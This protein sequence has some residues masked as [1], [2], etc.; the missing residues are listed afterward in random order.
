MAV[1]VK[2]GLNVAKGEFTAN[3]HT[4]A[5]QLAPD[6][7]G[8]S[9]GGFVVAYN[10]GSLSNG[11]MLLDFYDA[12]LDHVALGI[13]FDS[14]ATTDAIGEPSLTELA[15]GNVLVVWDENNDAG[16]Q[17][18]MKAALFEQDGTLIDANINLDS[19][20]IAHKDLDV[21]ALSNGNFAVS[22]AFGSFEMFRLY[23]S[24]GAAIGGAH[25]M[26]TVTTG[27]Q[28]DAQLTALAGGGFAAVWTD[29]NTNKLKGRIFEDNGDART[30]EF[31]LNGAGG[32]SQAAVVALPNGNWAVAFRDTAFSEPGPELAGIS[33]Q[34]FTPEGVDLISN[35]QVTEGT[36]PDETDPDVTVL[37]NGF[38]LVSWSRPTS[39]TNSDIMGRLFDQDGVAVDMLGDGGD[40]VITQSAT[41]D[42]LSSV[43][44]FDIGRFV[45]AWQDSDTVDGSSGRITG[46][47]SEMFRHSLGD[48]LRNLIVGDELRDVMVGGKGADT[49]DGGANDD[50]LNGGEGSDVVRG[51]EGVDLLEGFDRDDTIDGGDG[52][53][54]VYT[55]HRFQ[56][57]ASVDGVGKVTG[58][59]GDDRLFG[60]AGA[61]TL[62]GG[63]DDDRIE[64]GAGG[65]RLQGGQG[66][67]TLRGGEGNDTVEGGQGA[68]TNSQDNTIDGGAG[69]DR[70]LGDAAKDLMTGGLNNDRLFGSSGADTIDGGDGVDTVDYS[71]DVNRVNANLATG[72][73]S[74]L[75][76]LVFS[77]GDVYIGI[78]NIVG[79]FT[80]DTLVGDDRNNKI[81]GRTGND[82]IIGGDGND[83]LVGGAT[84][85]SDRITGGKGRDVMDAGLNDDIFIFLSVRDSLVADGKHDL[86]SDFDGAE[87][88]RIDLSAIDAREGGGDNAFVFVAAFT[89]ARGELIAPEISTGIFLVQGDVNG[90]AIA[91][92]AI[93][94]RVEEESGEVIDG[95]D[96]IL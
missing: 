3:T 94:V 38:I 92:F 71:G 26:N 10:N 37:S 33:L 30:D 15:N 39:A 47:V 42:T 68:G 70:L 13:P 54:T 19:G 40:F 85:G 35:I 23:T 4:L 91:D 5:D 53:D 49:L 6:T 58:G 86:V 57:G 69:D 82:T 52:A 2:F 51:G 67:D 24:A 81:E 18:G 83:T 31:A 95:G 8:L 88:D 32:N 9:G 93:E 90:D 60:A 25:I 34:L 64:G 7:L 41:N 89:G 22:F 72:V 61:D 96:F 28:R 75:A 44:G 1:T 20:G 46:R 29:A 12:D 73:G 84:G 55:L 36:E 59:D 17:A 65:D 16:S 80:G 50:S 56:N 77:A 74:G 79:G 66:R 27:T 43:S 14:T 76:S 78:E 62:I 11:L 45:A 21:T 48:D 87:G 63:F